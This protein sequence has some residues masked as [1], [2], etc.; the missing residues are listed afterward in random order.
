MYEQLV[1]PLNIHFQSAYNRL[2]DSPLAIISE[3]NNHVHSTQGK[4]LRPLLTMLTAC[5]CGLPLDVEADHP[6][7]AITAA[8]ETLH[9]STLI[10]DDVVDNSDTRRGQPSVN[11]RWGNKV[12]VLVGDFYLA[13]VM[14]TLNKVDNKEITSIINDAVIQMSEGEL[15]QQQHSG[16]YSADSDIY[17]AI[18]ERK[19][20]SFMA[21]CC[22]VGATFATS[23]KQLR[24]QA[25]L[26][27][28]NIGLAFQ[29]RDDILDY[30]PSSVSGKPQGN[31]LRE[32][33]CTLPLIYA[34]SHSNDE[35]K[36]KI[37]T[38]LKKTPLSDTNIQTIIK[39]V[40]ENGHLTSASKTLNHYLTLAHNA[41]QKLPDNKYREALIELTEKMNKPIIH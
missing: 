16:N 28:I 3:V 12:A 25:R 26:F 31:D 20:A 41:L 30:Q 22:Q 19:T 15:L 9:S 11:S 8:I 2:T 34:L 29:I 39:M 17:L 32:G 18:I 5:C 36:E 1:A 14:Q 33:K 24:E 23:D 27:G 13:K 40:D 21:A 10:H 7:F 38:L 4:Q 37:L 6:I 35:T